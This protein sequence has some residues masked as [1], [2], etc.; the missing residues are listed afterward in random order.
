MPHREPFDIKKPLVAARSFVF[1]GEPYQKGDRFPHSGNASSFAL[2][3]I[4]RQYESRTIAHADAPADEELPPEEQVVMTG[5]VGGRYKISAPWLE[6][7]ETVRGK[8]NAENRFAEI[9]AAGAPVGWIAGGSEVTVEGG[10]GG[11]F[12]ISA[13]WL[14][15]DE[16]HQGRDAAEQRQREL[17]AAGEPEIWAG[18]GLQDKGNG[19]YTVS[20]E[21]LD[22]PE[23]VHGI[24]A[25]KTRAAE[26]RSEGA[27]AAAESEDEGEVDDDTEEGD[28]GAAG[29]AGGTDEATDETSNDEVEETTDDA[30]P[31]QG[32]A[33]QI[34]GTGPAQAAD[35]VAAAAGDAPKE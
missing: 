15:E 20:A 32:E 25:A 16:K 12:T 5:P 19:Y 23:T 31:H 22:E 17:H 10:E 14:A 21:W 34:P 26:L 13:P 24:E 4:K 11:W 35:D 2:R 27:L 1:A 18:V 3:L 30:D 8:V 33:E 9:K 29:A 28:D 7:A 6:E